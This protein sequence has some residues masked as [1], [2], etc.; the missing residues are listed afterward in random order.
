MFI[1]AREFG[2]TGEN[3]YKDTRAIQKALNYAKKVNTLFLSQKVHII[4]EKLWSFM[5]L[6]RCYSMMRQ[7]FCE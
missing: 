1:N 5:I 2:L 7:F 6:Q 4:L 3:K